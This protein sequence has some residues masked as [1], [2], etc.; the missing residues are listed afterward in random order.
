MA[1]VGVAPGAKVD[2]DREHVG[3]GDAEAAAPGDALVARVHELD[4]VLGDSIGRTVHGDDLVVP[5]G[6][7]V[8]VDADDAAIP[9]TR[10]VVGDRTVKPE[11]RGV[12]GRRAK[13][14]AGEGGGERA[15]HRQHPWSMGS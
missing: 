7:R 6:V 2:G 10:V 3:A 14:Q 1:D 15:Q 8:R 13:Q 5:H 9:R 12:A 11:L 4:L